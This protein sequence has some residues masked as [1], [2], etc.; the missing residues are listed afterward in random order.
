MKVVFHKD[1]RE[2]GYVL[3]VLLLSV[4]LLSISLLAMMGRLEI[5]IKRDRE[6][7]LI[8]RGLEYS[9]AV[10]KYV[11]M[12]GRYPNSVEQLENSNNIRFLRK[13]YKD[14]ITG[15]DFNLLH[16]GDL[17]TFNASGASVSATS[18]ASPKPRILIAEDTT[19][20]VVPEG[21]QPEEAIN[22]QGVPVSNPINSSQTAS[23]QVSPPVEAD[24]SGTSEDTGGIAII[25]VA[26]FSKSK[27]IRVFNNKD[28]YDQWQFVYD[29]STDSGMMTAP[30]R[31]LLSRPVNSESP[32]GGQSS[33]PNSET[34][35][36]Q[37]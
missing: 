29:P 6:K 36:G 24:S 25:G 13:R 17:E 22:T 19:A 21:R 37:K 20:V 18:G 23:N 30:N 11:K 14:P 31:P 9:R 12:F 2:G 7:E 16:Y 8:H 15:K 28:H 1:R 33:T 34:N 35:S 5:Q 3:L 4:S 10:R 26:S 27:S 32:Q